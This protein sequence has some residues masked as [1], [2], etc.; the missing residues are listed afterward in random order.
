MSGG[1]RERKRAQTKRAIYDAAMR[2]FAEQ[3][4]QKTSID[5]IVAAAEVSRATFFNYFG[6]KEGVLHHYSELLVAHLEAVVEESKSQ[7]SPLARIR[8]F[9]DGWL[10][11]I[12]EHQLEA[13][14]VYLNSFANPGGLLNQTPSR[15]GLFAV[16]HEMVGE[17]QALREIRSDLTSRHLTGLILSVYQM[18]VLSFLLGGESLAELAESAWRFVLHGVTLRTD[19]SLGSAAAKPLP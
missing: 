15:R 3:G 7:P 6:S 4:F 12:A 5:Q 9:L 2:L 11:H 19:A 17:G 1:L 10:E 16:V 18:V 14:Q 8:R 13:R